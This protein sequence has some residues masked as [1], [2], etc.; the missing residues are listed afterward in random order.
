MHNTYPTENA[1]RFLNIYNVTT[2]KVWTKN[3]FLLRIDETKKYFI[4]KNKVSNKKYFVTKIPKFF[5]KFLSNF[6]VNT[7][8]TIAHFFWVVTTSG[9]RV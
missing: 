4:G 8:S 6:F 2:Q 9:G 5:S 1:E 3:N 7:L